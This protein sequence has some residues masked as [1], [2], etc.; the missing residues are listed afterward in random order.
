MTANPAWYAVQSLPYLLE[1]PY[2]CAE[3]TFSRLYA[4]LLAA[5]ILKSN[6]RFKT[7]LAEWTRQAQSGTAQQREQLAGK[8]AQNQELKNILLQETPWVRDAQGETARLA[9]LSSAV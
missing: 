6:P 7:V 9:R 3:Q 2:E 5:Q 1:Y 4:N 8:L